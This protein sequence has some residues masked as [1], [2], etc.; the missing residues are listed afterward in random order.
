MNY[1]DELNETIQRQAEELLSETLNDRLA[2]DLARDIADDV[3]QLE[4]CGTTVRYLL[5]DEHT[6]ELE[7][8]RLYEEYE[9]AEKDSNE[10]H[11]RH[12]RSCLVATLLCDA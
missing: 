10:L 1:Y 7:S 8:Q 5:I 11:K 6:G 2:E 12:E 3:V 4:R 9:E